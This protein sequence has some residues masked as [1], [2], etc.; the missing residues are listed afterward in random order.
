MARKGAE[1]K[2]LPQLSRIGSLRGPRVIL[3]P[4]LER[5]TDVLYDWFNDPELS[6]PWDKFS[7]DSY[8]VFMEGLHRASE[9]ED[10]LYPR[11]VIVE[12]GGEPIGV[13]GYYRSHRVFEGYDIWYLIAKTEK[14]GQGL[15]QEAAGLLV[16]YIFSHTM[17]ERV[18]ATS[19]VENQASVRLLT[20]LGFRRE[21][22]MKRV[23]FHHGDW[24][25]VVVY[26]ITRS[27]WKNR[28]TGT[29]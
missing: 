1:K 22:A 12:P 15:G 3:R 16:D 9:E 2:A 25:D 6:S 24:H 8:G 5:E 7:I 11:F 20:A 28:K 4:P 23:L 13:V 19:D 29:P 10:S 26:G 17:V 18:G 27:E 14:R 21:G